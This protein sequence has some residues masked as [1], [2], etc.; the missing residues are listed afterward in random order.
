MAVS[1]RAPQPLSR[2]VA[3]AGADKLTGRLDIDGGVATL[4]FFG[5]RPVHAEVQATASR[6][7]LLGSDAVEV[8]IADHGGTGRVVFSA[9]EI[10]AYTIEMTA[11]DLVGRLSPMDEAQLPSEPAKPGGPGYLPLL[12]RG[13][14]FFD[15]IPLEAV[16]LEALAP[17]LRDGAIVV[18]VTNAMGVVLVRNSSLTET[19]FFS[20]ELPLTGAAALTRIRGLGGAKVSAYALSSALID[21]APALLRGRPLY[22][23]VRL[24]WL[25]WEAFLGDMQKRPGVLVL[26]ISTPKGRGVACLADG[27]HVATYT[28]AHP[29]IG[30][31]GLLSEYIVER[32]GAVYVRTDPA[33][34]TEAMD[35]PYPAAPMAPTPP[36]NPGGGVPGPAPMMPQEAAPIPT[37]PPP[38][39]PLIPNA[40]PLGPTAAPT[41]A[42]APYIPPLPQNVGGGMVNAAAPV[43]PP[44][45]PPPPTIPAPPA[46]NDPMVGGGIPPLPPNGG[47]DIQAPAGWP[48]VPASAGA[49]GGDAAPWLASASVAPAAGGV[50]P[51]PMAELFGGATTDGGSSLRDLTPEFKQIARARLQRSASR[52]EALLDD[53]GSQNRSVTDI[54]DEIRSLTIRGV[55]PSTLE[56]VG[57]EMMQVARRRGAA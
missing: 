26:E 34:L 50:S 54:V 29:Q 22:E 31:L 43:P 5:G 3:A 15:S 24:G 23:D 27:V 38:P 32:E 7:P 17:A 55:M 11:D 2:F 4:F 45:M 46:M 47:G 16:V 41:P 18:T 13:K 56:A 20:G 51:P 30:D 44:V 49:V 52:V 42:P 14:P 28:D 57:E 25:D 1:T 36:M 10:P 48:P 8:I 33:P 37:V 39:S 6:G 40:G 21:C 9:S 12:P 19:F 35:L 53:A